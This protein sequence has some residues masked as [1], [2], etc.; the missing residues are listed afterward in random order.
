MCNGQ[1]HVIVINN[2]L[3]F[4]RINSYVY[5]FSVTFNNFPG[6][7]YYSKINN[8]RVP[9]RFILHAINSSV[10]SFMKGSFNMLPTLA[11]RNIFCT[12][13]VD[14]YNVPY[15]W[16]NYIFLSDRHLP[17]SSTNQSS[18]FYSKEL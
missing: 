5:I 15:S 2:F 18:P 9:E 4:S 7:H 12:L 13:A 6:L 10:F 14:D 17:C 1:T 16:I 3:S 8:C 11:T